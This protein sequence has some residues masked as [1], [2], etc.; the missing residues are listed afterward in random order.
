VAK[1]GKAGRTERLTVEQAGGTGRQQ[2]EKEHAKGTRFKGKKT[3]CRTT[4][5]QTIPTYEYS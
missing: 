4:G 5:I 2:S 3:N 1:I